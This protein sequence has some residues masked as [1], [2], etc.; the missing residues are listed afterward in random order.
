M[1]QQTEDLYLIISGDK[2]FIQLQHYG[3]VYQFSPLLKSFMG[4][5]E[6]A[7]TFLRE[8]IIKGDRSDSVLIY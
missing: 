5:N 3:N 6:N 4:E 1:A 2:D 7:V 8:Q